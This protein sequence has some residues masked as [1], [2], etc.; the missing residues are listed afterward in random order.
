MIGKFVFAST[1]LVGL[2]DA[3]ENSVPVYG[4]YPGWIQGGNLANIEVDIFFDYLCADTKAAFP[5]FVAALETKVSDTLTL[6]D[7]IRV[8]ASSFPLDYHLHSW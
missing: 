4:T 3:I 5:L 1:V 2:A 8:K 6:K 7:I